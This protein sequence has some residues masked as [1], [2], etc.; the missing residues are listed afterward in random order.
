[1]AL[2][3]HDD[4]A[5]QRAKRDPEFARRIHHPYFAYIFS[6]ASAMSGIGGVPPSARARCPRSSKKRRL[7]SCSKARR[8]SPDGRDRPVRVFGRRT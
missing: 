7:V 4:Y 6:A 3:R 1:M 2:T 8:C 5:C